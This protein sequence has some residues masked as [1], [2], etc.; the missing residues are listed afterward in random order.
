MPDKV[1]KQ[2]N[3]DS[4]EWFPYGGLG[5]DNPD[6]R[7]RAMYFFHGVSSLGG[8]F[9]GKIAFKDEI[10]TVSGNS[11]WVGPEKDIESWP[12]TE[13]SDP[14]QP[15][16]TY[17]NGD[18][19]Y[20]YRFNWNNNSEEHSR[21]RVGVWKPRVIL[22]GNDADDNNIINTNIYN[23]YVN[24]LKFIF[25]EDNDSIELSQIEDTNG[26]FWNPVSSNEFP[27]NDIDNFPNFNE[28][29]G[30]DRASNTDYNINETIATSNLL[31]K[32]N[33]LRN[34]D[35]IPRL[36]DE[37]IGGGPGV[38][39][40]SITWNARPSGG[41]GGVSR[42]GQFIVGD[43]VENYNIGDYLLLE[44]EDDE[45]HFHDRVVIV[46]DLFDTANNVPVIEI[47]LLDDEGFIQELIAETF[48]ITKL[49]NAP[50]LKVTYRVPDNTGSSIVV[51]DDVE[52]V[53]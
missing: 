32:A 22:D 44:A 24:A 20:R 36:P 19:C 34:N 31:Q 6:I 21:L 48:K 40:G 43:V 7:T 14:D 13:V 10:E 46:K 5:S 29:A 45:N 47:Q 39:V 53:N 23:R 26:S 27:F 4:G 52:D 8:V 1:I 42:T 17:T 11:S 51:T 33:E 35:D 18:T 38:D 50:K 15:I 2:Y 41:G 28:D 25:G 37:S 30:I 3:P 16:E 49:T 9:E 12:I